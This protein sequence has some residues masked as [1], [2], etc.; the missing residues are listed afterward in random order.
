MAEGRHHSPQLDDVPYLR[1]PSG[2]PPS[3]TFLCA[4]TGG[5][6]LIARDSF[7]A[8]Q[9]SVSWCI[10]PLLSLGADQVIK[11]N[12]NSANGD[13]AVVAFHL[14]HYP[15][16]SQQ[17]DICRR[18]AMIT[19]SS[20]STVC[21]TLSQQALVNNKLYF[22]LYRSLIDKNLLKRKCIP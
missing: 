7:S 13:G 8:G 3:P 17:R 11:I 22:G 10:S 21:I 12:A 6:K 18:I 5:G 15:Q 2:I 19:G 4:P 16:P 14:D 9:G 20:N 1:H